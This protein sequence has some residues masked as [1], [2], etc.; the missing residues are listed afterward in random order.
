MEKKVKKLP[1]FLENKKIFNFILIGGLGLVLLIFFGD[2]LFSSN[3]A[4]KTSQTQ[5]AT[6]VDEIEKK[7]EAKLLGVLK[8]I[9]GI[10]ELDVMVTLDSTTEF[11]FAEDGK[12]KSGENNTF[13]NDSLTSSQ[14]NSEQETNFIL[15]EG[16]SGRKEA[17][18]KTIIQPKIRGVIVQCESGDSPFIKEKVVDAVSKI[19]GISSARISVI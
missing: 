17:L 4:E 14:K 2:M 13:S 1:A 19:F 7:L 18:V 16:S 8:K 3:K 9:D 15:V 12:K 6:N 11:V 10:G 5:I